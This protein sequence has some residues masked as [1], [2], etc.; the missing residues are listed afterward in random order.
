MLSLPVVPTTADQADREHEERLRQKWLRGHRQRLRNAARREQVNRENVWIFHKGL[1][2]QERLLLF[3]I[4]WRTVDGGSMLLTLL[5]LTRVPEWIMTPREP[6][7]LAR[8]LVMCRGCVMAALENVWVRDYIAD[9]SLEWWTEPSV[10]QSPPVRVR[11]EEA[12]VIGSLGSVLGATDSKHSWGP[13]IGI[14]PLPLD[15]EVLERNVGYLYHENSRYNRRFEQ[16]RRIKKALGKEYRRLVKDAM[17]FNQRDFLMRLSPAGEERI[18]RVLKLSPVEFW[19]AARGV[20][21][22]E[23]GKEWKQGDLFTQLEGV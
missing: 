16:R 15:M 23:M 8:A 14:E 3:S 12:S 20:A 11:F 5:A 2:V 13:I 19:R 9:P 22:L 4:D 10:R 21:V 1:I 7:V 6:E 18:K 17:Y